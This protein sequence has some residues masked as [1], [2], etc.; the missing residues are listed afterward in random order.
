MYFAFIGKDK[1]GALDLRKSTRDEHVAFLK[2]L[3]NLKMAGPLLDDDGQ[4]CGSLL[5]LEAENKA[6]VEATLAR[7]P[8][9]RVGLFETTDIKGL[10]W[11]FGAPQ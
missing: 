9:A 8:Y 6:E 4:M 2:T 7:D 11:T 3:A 10:N 5:V 1:P